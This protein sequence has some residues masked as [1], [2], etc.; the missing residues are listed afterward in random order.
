M[1]Q[2]LLFKKKDYNKFFSL[3]FQW[4]KKQSATVKK[5]EHIL[6]GDCG[7]CSQYNKNINRKQQYFL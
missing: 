7:K 1:L 6:L 4:K 5:K 3:S 2:K